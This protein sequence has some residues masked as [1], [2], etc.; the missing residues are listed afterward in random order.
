LPDGIFLNQKSHFWLI[1]ESLAMED[2]GIFMAIWSIFQ[3]FGRFSGHFV[4]FVA[5]WH[6]FHPVLVCCTKK[7]LAALL[8]TSKTLH[9]D[10]IPTFIFPETMR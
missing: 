10:G 8:N 2:V 4:Y 5:I 6:I 3:P 9:P 7:N 1:L